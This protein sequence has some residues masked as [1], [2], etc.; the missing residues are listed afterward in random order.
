MSL[1]DRPRPRG[2]QP[3]LALLFLAAL[4][5]WGPGTLAQAPS[6]DPVEALRQVLSASEQ[7]PEQR[8]RATRECLGGLRSLGDLRRAACLLEWRDQYPDTDLAAVDQAN[9][10][11]VVDRFAKAVREVLGRGDPTT[12]A[13][14]CDMLVE[15]ATSARERGD[16]HSL[17]APF[18]RD[19]IQLTRPET[20]R[21]RAVA[22]RALGRID[23]EVYLAVPALADLL[24]APD[25]ALRRAAVEG[26]AALLQ[27][28]AE[29]LSR[30]GN[31]NRLG[32]IRHDVVVA[33]GSVVPAVSRGLT[34]AD[35][36][37]RR[38]CARTVGLAGAALGRLVSDPPAG[39][40]TDE[41]AGRYARQ[42]VL[43]EQVELRPL[44]LVLRDQ[45]AVLARA[46]R[47]GD[48]ETRSLARKTLEELANARWRWLRQQAATVAPAAALDDPL[49]EGFRPAL[50]VLVEQLADPDVGVRRAALDIL[51]FLGPLAAPAVPRLVRALN[52][53]DRFV[54][55]SAI[56][57]L[58][59]V[60]PAAARPALPGLTRLLEDRDV[61]LR[62]AAAAAIERLDPRPGTPVHQASAP[63]GPPASRMPLPALIRSL[64]E[65]DAE[66]RVAAM[67]TLR[68][69]DRVAR[70][71]VPA[72][73]E[74]LTASDA[75]VRRAAA[76][77][78]GAL[79]PVAAGA[80]DDLQRALADP[81]PEVRRAAG[82]ALLAVTR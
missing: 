39:H 34:D 30:P 33:A 52:D 74:A 40:P 22:A 7:T 72:L 26:L 3:L 41:A 31:A 11:L 58:S 54:R 53:A 60:G 8:D 45:G 77:T 56:R 79:G 51:E 14:V 15:I 59:N 70:P 78:L 46:L 69:M 12:T 9:R 1:K 76:E 82:D 36:E 42:C 47:D 80:A 27:A 43:A 68:G 49:A 24:Q 5:A 44:L 6:G 10:A 66:M 75:R 57:A 2:S 62:L 48:P 71:A 73:C 4:T 16:G 32:A 55:W 17:A 64:R 37:V 21:V 50:P 38:G 29:G 19:L 81:D 18:S 65:G 35:A 20:P 13:V 23:A 28:T 25:P 63:G 67:H 61:D